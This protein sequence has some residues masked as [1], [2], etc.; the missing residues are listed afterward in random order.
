M[1]FLPRLRSFLGRHIDAP[2]DPDAPFA[3]IGD[4]HGR[5]DLLERLLGRL[6]GELPAG[7][8]L[9]LLGDYVDRGAASA[10]VLRRLQAL[11]AEARVTCL[12]GN[13]EAMLIE[14][15]DY[16]VL[17][18]PRWLRN[19]GVQ[20][21]ESFGVTGMP[22]GPEASDWEA[23]RDRFRGAMGGDL[24]T[25]LRAR[26]LRWQSG[27]VAAVHAGADP[28]RPLSDQR[29]D[30]LL[31]GHPSFATMRRRDGTWV[32]HGHTIV[33]RPAAAGGRISV[34]TGAYATGVLTAAIVE[35]GS[36]RFVST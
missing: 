13:H 14:F 35:P 19:G 25:W 11:D 31:W 3:A 27:N 33:P 28:A 7:A 8:P 21:L 18:G 16:P 29:D 32:V 24:E 20:T 6:E 4:V 1:R 15:L 5:D 30:V 9:V 36:V 10:G 23:L 34:D 12:C 26:P 17:A 22:A 2:L